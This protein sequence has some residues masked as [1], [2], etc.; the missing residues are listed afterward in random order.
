[1][2][3][4]F[5]T[6][7]AAVSLL[8]VP[9]VSSA[10]ADV[11]LQTIHGRVTD[12][13]DRPLRNVAVSDGNH[14]VYTDS[15]GMYSI[16]EQLPGR[17]QITVSRLGLDALPPRTVGPWRSRR[18]ID[19]VETYS[20]GAA[21]HPNTFDSSTTST[22]SIAVDTYTP[23]GGSCAF[24]NDE[25][26]GEVVALTTSAILPRGDDTTTWVGHFSVAGLPSGTYASTAWTTDCDGHFLSRVQSVGYVVNN[27]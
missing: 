3:R 6:I 9:L 16:G 11:V 10:R 19:F 25:S 15:D 23:R 4:T 20:L 26:S 2:R 24:W 1:M 17:Y 21:L 18:S 13:I 8:L 7:A 14:V 5:I 12:T 27:A 22:I